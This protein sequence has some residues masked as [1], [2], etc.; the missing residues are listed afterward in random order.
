MFIFW[1]H[2]YLGCPFNYIGLSSKPCI[3]R[4]PAQKEQGK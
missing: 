3:K 1:R 4:S 2:Q